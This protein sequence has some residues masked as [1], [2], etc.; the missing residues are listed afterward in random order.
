MST[1][2]GGSSSSADVPVDSSVATSVS[3]IQ[4]A[5]AGTICNESKAQHFENLTNLVS[6]SN[7]CPG[8]LGRESVQGLVKTCFEMCA[9]RK[10]TRQPLSTN[11]KCSLT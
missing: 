6:T 4:P 3:G 8:L 9:G 7:A 5:T 1:F 10:S 11:V 2:Q